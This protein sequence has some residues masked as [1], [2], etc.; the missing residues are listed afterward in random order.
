MTVFD[1]SRDVSG[2]VAYGLPFCD[3]N[4]SVELAAGVEQTLTVP[5]DTNFSVFNVV[6]SFTPGGSVWV[7]KGSVAV[8]LPGAAFASTPGVLNPTVRT[9][10]AGETLR[11]ITGDSDTCVGV[12]FYGFS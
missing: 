9:A 1:I 7:G 10:K 11:F 4:Q 5:N 12:S 8:A 6:F 3:N 2:A